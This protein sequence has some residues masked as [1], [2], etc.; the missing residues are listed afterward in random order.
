MSS[1]ARSFK[2]VPR[3]AQPGKSRAVRPAAKQASRLAALLG[4]AERLA[5]ELS[6]HPRLRSLLDEFVRGLRELLAARSAV[7]VMATPEQREPRLFAYS[8]ETP[9]EDLALVHALC[10]ASPS[11]H[12]VQEAC[13]ELLQ[14]GEPTVLPINDSSAL[15][16]PIVVRQRAMGAVMLRSPSPR[17]YGA[18][19]E[20][21]LR[22]LVHHVSML[23]EKIGLRDLATRDELTGLPSRRE[24]VELLDAELNR[25]RRAELTL[26]IGLVDLDEFREINEQ[27]GHM[28]GDRV[29]KILAERLGAGLRKSD[30]VGRYGGDE[31]LL[32]LP[33][34]DGS[35][36]A[37]LAQRLRRDL[38]LPVSLSAEEK[39][40][41]RISVGFVTVLGPTPNVLPHHEVIAR[42]DRALEVARRSGAGVHGLPF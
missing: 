18:A 27:F 17:P 22:L 42:A 9:R 14:E 8:S 38:E 37:R 5:N 3:L 15:C 33:D 24:V 25:C 20:Q 2:T 35:G 31:F 4:E 29:L 10:G 7:V 30:M 32:I 23:V 12:A 6:A 39:A 34:T 11:L 1:R 16:V 40:Q 26:T 21:L 28:V 19:E 41:V 36:A 13:E